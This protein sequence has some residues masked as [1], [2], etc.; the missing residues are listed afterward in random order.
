MPLSPTPAKANLKNRPVHVRELALKHGPLAFD[1]LLEL[2]ESKDERLALAVAQ[3]ILNRA[4]GKADSGRE[5][6]DEE[7]GPTVIVI[8]EG[9][10]AERK[11]EAPAGPET[12]PPARRRGRSAVPVRQAMAEAPA[13]E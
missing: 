4:Y 1:R 5:G 10:L 7:S 13:R 8:R 3:E 11:V 9:G 12:A 6:R 2:L